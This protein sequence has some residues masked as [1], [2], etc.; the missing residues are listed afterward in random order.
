[1]IYAYPIVSFR[2]TRAIFVR[3]AL[4]RLFLPLLLVLKDRLFDY[5]SGRKLNEA[6]K[7]LASPGSDNSP[8]QTVERTPDTQ[9][10][11]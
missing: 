7:F 9:R 8:N 2:L 11:D 4:A 3:G 10:C 1:M 5:R 6:H